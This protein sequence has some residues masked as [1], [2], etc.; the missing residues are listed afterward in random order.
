AGIGGRLRKDRQR[1]EVDDQLQPLLPE[2][3]SER[4]AV[5]GPHPFVRHDDGELSALLQDGDG[6]LEKIGAAFVLRPEIRFVSDAY[7]SGD[8]DNTGG[9]LSSYRI[10]DLFLFYYGRG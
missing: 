2:P 8:N 1:A 10:Y 3:F 7:L 9:K 6:Q 5:I 4:R